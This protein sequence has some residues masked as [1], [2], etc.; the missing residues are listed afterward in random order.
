M[1]VAKHLITDT[2]KDLVSKLLYYDRKDDDELPRGAIEEAID[3]GVITRE[4][5]AEAF[6][7][8]LFYSL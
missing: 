2:V 1:P 3:A 5:I 6:K 7:E 8:A 4:E